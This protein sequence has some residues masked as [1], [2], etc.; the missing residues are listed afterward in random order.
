MCRRAMYMPDGIVM[1]FLLL[2]LRYPLF[3]IGLELVRFLPWTRRDIY[4]SNEIIMKGEDDPQSDVHT[5]L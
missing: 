1:W 2:F 3:G 4:R 5:C